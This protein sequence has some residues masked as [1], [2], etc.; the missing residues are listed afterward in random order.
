MRVSGSMIARGAVHCLSQK[1]AIAVS[2]APTPMFHAHLFKKASPA[3]F[4][5]WVG[6][7]DALHTGLPATLHVGPLSAMN[8]LFGFQ[9][10]NPSSPN[11]PK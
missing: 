8:R 5:V 9:G 10:N 3:V 4:D 6:S 2:I 1:K 11:S 7:L